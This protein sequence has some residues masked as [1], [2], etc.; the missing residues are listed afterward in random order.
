MPAPVL[1]VMP[2]SLAFRAL[3]SADLGY[4]FLPNL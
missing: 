3:A 1:S 2:S 4:F